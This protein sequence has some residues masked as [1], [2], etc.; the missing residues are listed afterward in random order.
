MADKNEWEEVTSSF[1]DKK[2]DY[3][4]EYEKTN[5]DVEFEGVLKKVEH[6]IGQ[7][8]SSLYTIE[9]MQG[10][11]IAVWGAT[12]LDRSM[13]SLIN[14][15]IVTIGDMIKIIYEGKKKNP[16]TGRMFNSFKVFKKIG[17]KK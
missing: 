12:A 6:D 16:N 7:Y 3:K 11:E 5:K 8:K 17:E 10:E 4:A 1:S 14:Q 2:W 9:N 13:S 15:G